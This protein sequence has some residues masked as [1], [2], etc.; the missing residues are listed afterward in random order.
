MVHDEHRETVREHLEQGDGDAP[1]GKLEVVR[2]HT[3][4]GNGRVVDVFYRVLPK[5]YAMVRI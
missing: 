3:S 2:M 5:R 4:H 1:V